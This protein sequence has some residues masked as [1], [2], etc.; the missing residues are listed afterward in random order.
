MIDFRCTNC[1]KEF[2]VA[3][4]LAGKRSTCPVCKTRL[5]V[6]HQLPGREPMPAP[7]PPAAPLPDAKW[8]GW[9]ARLRRRPK[10]LYGC[11]A[12]AVVAAAFLYWWHPLRP[13][14]YELD[15]RARTTMTPMGWN[16]ESVDLYNP[17]SDYFFVTAT[18]NRWKA[19][20]MIFFRG[21]LFSP[22]CPYVNLHPLDDPY[23][24][25]GH[26]L[27]VQVWY[28]SNEDSPT[29]TS[30]YGKVESRVPDPP[31]GTSHYLTL[32]RGCS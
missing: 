31:G 11:F 30:Y 6:P 32:Q 2:W 27:K 5:V 10:T 23:P 18:K 12:G 8:A 13:G 17:R 16:V 14:R 28:G 26:Q 25:P 29:V 4:N 21:S 1:S 3:D 9:V 22:T 24:R 20:G 19:H 15:V 7:T